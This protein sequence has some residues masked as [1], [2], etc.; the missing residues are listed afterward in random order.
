MK[1]K[2]GDIAK[3]MIDGSLNYFQ[4]AEAILALRDELGI[5]ANDPDFVVFVGVLSEIEYL[6]GDAGEFNWELLDDPALKKQIS[7]SLA[8][9]KSISLENCKSLARRYSVIAY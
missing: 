1:T 2:I 8:W 9:A 5:Y 7:E 6:R 3:A 4:G